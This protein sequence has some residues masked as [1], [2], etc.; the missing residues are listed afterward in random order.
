[1][2]YRSVR[3]G[4]ISDSFLRPLPLLVYPACPAC[5]ERSRRERSRR[6]RSRRAAPSSPGSVTRLQ[7]SA[8]SAPLRHPDPGFWGSE[9][10]LRHIVGRETANTFVHRIRAAMFA[11]RV[12]RF[13]LRFTEHGSR[14]TFRTPHPLVRK[15]LIPK[16]LNLGGLQNL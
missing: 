12:R 4:C 2:V 10:Q 11:A 7:N 14:N 3:F 13:L 8:S 16:D 9:L 1:M 15:F 6:E 5:P